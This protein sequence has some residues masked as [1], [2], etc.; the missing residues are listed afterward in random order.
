MRTPANG[1]S[2]IHAFNYKPIL[3]SLGAKVKYNPPFPR[4]LDWTEP[5]MSSF[6]KSS[7]I[8]DKVLGRLVHDCTWLIFVPLIRTLQLRDV[9]FYDIIIIQK[10]LTEWFEYLF[11]ERIIVCL[12]KN[13]RKTFIYHFDDRVSS[14]NMAKVTN[15]LIGKG[16]AV[17]T[18][19]KLLIQYGSKI[20]KNIF[21]IPENILDK[22][23]AKIENLNANLGSPV[24]IGWLGAGGGYK[25]DA[26]DKIGGAF[27]KLS[28]EFNLK[29]KIV[30]DCNFSFKKQSNIVVENVKWTSERDSSFYC[31]IGINPLPNELASEGKGSFKLLKYMAHGIP[32]VTSWTCDDFNRNEVTC[33]VASSEDEWYI[34]M[35]RLLCDENLRQKLVMNGINEAKKYST[36]ALGR[37]YFEIISQ[38]INKH[39]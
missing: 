31:D 14:E 21:L 11:F 2:R 25:Y 35:R 23:I 12:A 36:T 10:G 15:Y 6:F 19:N 5:A 32:S 17:I 20:N 3:K 13:M 18:V 9:F 24:E 37:R 33:L 39:Q 16:K 4:S 27:E 29:L 26:L 22:E 8:I 28:K 1:S 38:T 34:Q 7:K 30:S